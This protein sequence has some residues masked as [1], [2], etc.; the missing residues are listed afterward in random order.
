MHGTQDPKQRPLAP[1]KSHR[2]IGSL[3]VRRGSV[4]S[5]GIRRGP[6][7]PEPEPEIQA[8]PGIPLGPVLPRPTQRR[9]DLRESPLRQRGRSLGRAQACRAVGARPVG[10]SGRGGGRSR[11]QVSASIAGLSCSIS[12]MTGNNWRTSW[13]SSGYCAAHSRS[14][15]AHP[16][17]HRQNS[18]SRCSTGSPPDAEVMSPSTETPLR[19]HVFIL[20]GQAD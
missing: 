11:G 7:G 2:A 18:S 19:S 3:S 9:A 6:L 1:G 15:A 10:Y 8:G 4:Q 20:L 12:T 5:R 16:P 13:T 14:R 17:P